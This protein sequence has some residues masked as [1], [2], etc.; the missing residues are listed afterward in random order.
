MRVW[1]ALAV[2]LFVFGKAVHLKNLQ[3]AA[4]SRVYSPRALQIE[5]RQL[6]DGT[7][8]VTAVD[9]ATGEV[10]VSHLPAT[11]RPELTAARP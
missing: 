7:S 8:V 10:F 1:A 6:D 11:P 9:H 2:F 5:S 4:E 3:H